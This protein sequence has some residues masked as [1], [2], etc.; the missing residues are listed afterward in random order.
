M[1]RINA[2]H[3]PAD[4]DEEAQ[5]VT[6]EQGDIT[7]IQRFVG[8]W[9]G[10]VS[11]GDESPTSFWHHDDGKILGLP[12]NRRATLLLCA[13]DHRW[14]GHDVLVGDIL[15]TGDPDDEGDTQS[16][17]QELVDLI[18]HTQPYKVEVQAPGPDWNSNQMRYESFWDALW[19]AYDLATRWAL[20]SAWRVAAA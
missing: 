18:F 14:V 3:V 11:A 1:A 7:V 8:G 15:L 16:V 13:L 2:I 17:S 9:F 4:D 6:I 19:A 5:L 12:V 20:V 10:V